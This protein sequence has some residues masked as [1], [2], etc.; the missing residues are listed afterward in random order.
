MEACILD[1]CVTDHVT[2]GGLY[3]ARPG[4]CGDSFVAEASIEMLGTDCLAMGGSGSN[5]QTEWGPCVVSRLQ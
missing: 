4:S 3:P 1:M 2:Y 5:S